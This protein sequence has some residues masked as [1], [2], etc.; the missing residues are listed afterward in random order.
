[1]LDLVVED[2]PGGGHLMGKRESGALEGGEF[3]G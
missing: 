3:T 1:M 2:G